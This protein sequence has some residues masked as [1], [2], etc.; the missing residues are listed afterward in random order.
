MAEIRK[1]ITRNDRYLFENEA[2]FI[3]HVLND[4][5]Y[6]HKLQKISNNAYM[7]ELPNID[8]N[9]D[10]KNFLKEELNK[11][12]FTIYKTNKSLRDLQQ[13]HEKKRLN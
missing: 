2:K 9:I 13:I 1:V 4:Y 10:K 6:S 7:I 12:D 8:K 3:V 11:V 5:N